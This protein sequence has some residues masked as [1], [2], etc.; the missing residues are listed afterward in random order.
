MWFFGAYQYLRDYDSQ[1]GTDPAHPRAFEQNKAFGVARDGKYQT[2]MEAPLPYIYRPFLQDYEEMTLHVRVA[3][4]T[5]SFLPVLRSEIRAVDAELPILRLASLRSETAFATLPQR[6]AATL[7]GACAAL[8]LL[9]A[10]I[11]LYGVVAYAVSQRTREIGI[12]MALGAGRSAVVRMVL[13]GSM[14]LVAL[15]LVI[16]LAL[17]LAAGRAVES[18][19]GDVSS[20]DP[21]ALVAGPV[22][23]IACALVASWLP[24]RRA[25]RIDPMLALREE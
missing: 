16:G 13:G 3:S 24:A 6:I 7:L 25:A 21:V 17:S 22:V 9:L 5:S 20:A 18:F 14:K 12:R 19:L 23:M 4:D 10:A 1:P 15:G 8:A 2:L 11:G